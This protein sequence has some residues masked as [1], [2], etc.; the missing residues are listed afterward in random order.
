MI[1]YFTGTGN[2]RYCAQMLADK[3]DDEIVDAFHFIRNGIPAELISGKPWIFVA[4]TY[5]WQ[6]PRIF[7]DF[8]R[9]G[10]FLGSKDAYF[11]MTCGSEIGNPE[12]KNKALCEEIGLRFLGTLEVVMP[13]NYIVMFNAP[14]QDKACEIVA[15][16]QPMLERGA[17]RIRE[18]RAFPVHKAGITDKLKSGFVN[19]MF[20]RICVKSKAFF[21]SRNCIGCGRCEK[22]CPLGNIQMKN[23]TPAWGD[24]CTHCMACICG[25]P[26]GAIEYGKSSKGKP[27]YQ[28]PAYKNKG[29]EEIKNAS[30]NLRGPF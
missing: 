18:K 13:E 14:G 22:A 7:V 24:R 12:P 6:L 23:G 17:A 1:V 25:C 27:R 29:T 28:C 5:G 20:Y 9:S 4:P 16:A 26:A 8:I 15:A 11:V 30:I 19:D 3:L 21:V 10:S 2:S